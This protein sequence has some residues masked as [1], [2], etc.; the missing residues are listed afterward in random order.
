[1]IFDDNFETINPPNPEIKMG[2]TM[3]RLLKTKNYEYDDPF[4]NE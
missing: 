4:G 1:V 3:D 2:D